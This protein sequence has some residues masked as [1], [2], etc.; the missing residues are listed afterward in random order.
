MDQKSYIVNRFIKHP[1]LKVKSIE[2]D[3]IVVSSN[4]KSDIKFSIICILKNASIYDIYINYKQSDIVLS[5]SKFIHQYQNNLNSFD[6]DLDSIDSF[7]SHAISGWKEK[8]FLFGNQYYKVEVYL[9]N[10]TTPLIF[11]KAYIKNIKLYAKLYIKVFLKDLE[12]TVITEPVI[13]EEEHII[14]PISTIS[15]SGE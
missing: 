11:R 7:L 5:L 1:Y 10:T 13:K 12:S 15:Q 9:K 2:D 8:R 14:K 6:F 3:L 4:K